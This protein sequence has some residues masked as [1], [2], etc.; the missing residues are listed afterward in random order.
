M[1]SSG[2]LTDLAATARKHR[3]MSKASCRRDPEA[4]VL[5]GTRGKN[6]KRK[7]ARSAILI[8]RT[9]CPV[10]VQCATWAASEDH[11]PYNWRG[12]VLGGRPYK[13]N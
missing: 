12:V 5:T 10:Y 7:K 2:G 8:C 4:F 11:K 6:K 9:E 1:F 3:W 13:E